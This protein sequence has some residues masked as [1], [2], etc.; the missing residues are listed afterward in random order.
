MVLLLAAALI[1]I[2]LKFGYRSA[3]E[4]LPS[5]EPRDIPYLKF[6][7]TLISIGIVALPIIVASRDEYVA[8]PGI[9]VEIIAGIVLWLSSLTGYERS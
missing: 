9:W 2:W 6:W 8:A 1:V 5:G 3:V 4:F 7:M